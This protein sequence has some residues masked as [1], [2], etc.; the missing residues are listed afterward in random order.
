MHNLDGRFFYWHDTMAFLLRVGD[1][2]AHK[3]VLLK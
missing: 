2:P 3:V 1:A